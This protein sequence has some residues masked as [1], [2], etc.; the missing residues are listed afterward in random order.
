MEKLIFE[1]QTLISGIIGIIAGYTLS[2]IQGFVDKKKQKRER[3]FK[4]YQNLL[5]N[6]MQVISYDFVSAFNMLLIEFKEDREI[7]NAREKFLETV[8]NIPLDDERALKAQQ[9]SFEDALI[10]LITL[11]GKR[12]NINIEQMDIKNRLYWPQAYS[13]NTEQQKKLIETLIKTQNQWSNVLEK[14]ELSLSLK[15]VIKAK[16]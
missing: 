5:S 9:C 2:L 4:I 6:V 12:I 11:V 15:P 8:T 16:K 10:R 7:L 1:Y 14:I 13:N 3:R